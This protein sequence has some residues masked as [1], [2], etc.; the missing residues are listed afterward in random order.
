MSEAPS[1]KNS[2]PRWDHMY[3]RFQ[4]SK[5]TADA[6]RSRPAA[7]LQRTILSIRVRILILR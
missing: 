3:V 6:T 7:R 2:E 5:S 4:L 1:M